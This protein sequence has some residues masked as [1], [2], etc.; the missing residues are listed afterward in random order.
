MDIKLIGIFTAIGLSLLLLYTRKSKQIPETI[1]LSVTSILFVFGGLNLAKSASINGDEFL[2]YWGLC[3]PFAYYVTDRLFRKLAI[4]A[5]NRDFILW[6][7]GSFEIDDSL[8]GSN[9][10]VKTLDIVFSIGLLVLI[11][12]LTTLG[13]VLSK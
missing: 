10:H 11:I 12:G 5:Y 6:L 7:R 1:R 3:V 9:P 4:M 8:F 13:A 2:L